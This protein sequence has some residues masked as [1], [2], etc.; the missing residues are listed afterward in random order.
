MACPEFSAPVRRRSPL[1]LF[2]GARWWAGRRR[3]RRARGRPPHQPLANCRRV[4]LLTAHPAASE[5]T[6]PSLPPPPAAS[7]RPPA[8]D[9]R[10]HRPTARPGRRRR[11]RRRRSPA[12]RPTLLRILKVYRILVPRIHSVYVQGGGAIRRR[13]AAPH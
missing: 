10:Q 1:S 8:A 4:R 11:H 2:I 7:R 3:V 6:G 9:R 12:L 13:A 5:H